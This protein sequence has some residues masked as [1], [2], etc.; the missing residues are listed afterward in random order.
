[1]SVAT[2][3]AP[4]VVIPAPDRTMYA[5]SRLASV[6]VLHA[7]AE[8]APVAWRLTRRGVV[9]VTIAVLALGVALIWL[10]RTSAP[11]VASPASAPHV[12]TVAPGDTLWS[13]AT[14][15]APDVDPRAEVAALQQRNGLSGVALVPGQI[16]RVP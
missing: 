14:R 12:V 10:A 5:P 4:A 7:P 8:P 1:M 9:V 2:E 15:V 16:L 3:F 13:I 11:Q 6:S